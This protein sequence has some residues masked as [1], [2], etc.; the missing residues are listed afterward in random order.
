MGITW[1]RGDDTE[2]RQLFLFESEEYG[3]DDY[4][5]ISDMNVQSVAIAEMRM[6][7]GL[8]GRKIEIDEA[9]ALYLFNKYVNF[10]LERDLELPDGRREYGFM[11]GRGEKLS[12]GALKRLQGKTCKRMSNDYESINY[13]LMRCFGGDKE[14]AYY[15]CDREVDL[16]AFDRYAVS[17][18]YKNTIDD[19]EFENIYHCESIIEKNG[20]YSLIVSEVGLEEREIIG[21]EIIS[22]MRLSTDE[23]MMVLAKS[24][25]ITVYNILTN[26]AAVEAILAT[27]PEGGSIMPFEK[28]NCY[29]RYNINNEHVKKKTYWLNEDVLGVYFVASGKQV[30]AEA[31]H[32]ES[33]RKI[34]RKLESGILTDYLEPMLRYE[35]T[36]KGNV[37]MD[38]MQSG[39]ED[40][41]EFIKEITSE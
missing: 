12:P 25:Y 24:E 21:V 17:T 38:F 37:L 34:E 32:E 9:E 33:I 10:N 28:G 30:I 5:G 7:R 26:A 35:F 40:F 39:S 20:R 15:I 31:Y 2:L 8:G 23:A 16:S 19:A 18:M 4:I 11:I 29:T 6:R 36:G 41:E 13:F 27:M 3:F 14:G 1:M 22:E